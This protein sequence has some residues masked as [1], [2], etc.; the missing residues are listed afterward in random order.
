[1]RST[2]SWDLN[3]DL[4]EGEPWTRTRALLRQVTST[5]VACGGHAGDALTME[6][7][8]VEAKALGVRLGAHPGVAGAFGRG[9]VTL[10][11]GELQTLV[12]QQAGGLAQLAKRHG[13]RL[14]HIK[15]HGALYHAVENDDAL[16]RA[17]VETVARWFP[18]VTI[19]SR[20]GGLVLTLA[21]KAGI[22]ARAEGFIDRAYRADGQLVPRNQD[23]A[24]LTRT[25]EIND[26]LRE[27]RQTGGWK[28]LDGTWVAVPAQTLCLHGDTPG[29]VALARA[30]RR[31]MER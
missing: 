15:L 29:A 1:M 31:T 14:H 24:L 23:G 19:Y 20:A 27:W 10:S 25:R 6:R 7:V 11:P 5:N 22:T 30:I 26:R 13:S 12:L 21:H 4:G 16:G 3:C 8:V 17:Y 28:S 9:E 2:A 18:K